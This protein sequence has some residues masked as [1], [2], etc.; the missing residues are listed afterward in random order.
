MDPQD[1]HLLITG[2]SSGIGAALVQE[3]L[4]AGW[5]VSGF[6]RRLDRLQALQE[7]LGAQGQRFLPVVADV[8][9]GPGL[10]QAVATAVAQHGPL[11]AI[12][13]NAGRG[14]D[15]EIS[16][17]TD[18]DLAAV[19]DVNVIGVHRTLRACLPHCSTNAR[20]IA[21]SSVAAF[22][23]IPRMG[24]Y[25]ASKAALQSWVAAAR[26]ELQDQGMR[27]MAC[28]PGTVATEFFSVAP[29]PG[30]VW[31]WRPGT[32]LQP[33][34]VARRILRQARKGR[35]HTT[36]LPW[37]AGIAAVSYRWLPR[38]TEWTMRRALR[39]MRQGE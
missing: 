13:A 8:S 14:V 32:P 24:A 25:C 11:S 33:Q 17:L 18:D 9:D 37:F 35:P 38:L 22:L 23:P 3:A 34:Q 15:G 26:M 1:K 39:R 12:V 2:A 10:Q 28:C 16:Q 30:A 27:I 19:Y 21:V 4:A 6:A 7:S 36:L 31:N 29:K 20:F 5:L